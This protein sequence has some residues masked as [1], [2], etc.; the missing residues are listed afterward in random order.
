MVP[1]GLAHVVAIGAGDYHSLAVK[2]DGSIIAWGDDSQGQLDPPAGLGRVVAL[3][4]GS[5][6]TIALLADTTAAAWGN[7]WNG[8][9]DLPVGISN[10]VAIAAGNS[11]TLLLEGNS[12]AQPQLSQ[13]THS[14]SRFQVV[15]QTFW[16]KTY[17][18][19]Y[20]D[21]LSNAAWT[22][23]ATILGNGNLQFLTDPTA[24]GPKRFYRVR[25]Y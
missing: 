2:S 3:A 11:H 19:E 24:S 1:F 17:V 25:Q 15:L 14:G 12:L 9:I 5:G 4:G 7:D 13:P 8:Q 10:V 21:D 16:G 20:K 18:L 22:P 23:A 6:H